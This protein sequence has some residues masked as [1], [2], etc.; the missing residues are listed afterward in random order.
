MLAVAPTLPRL[1]TWSRQTIRQHR[2]FVML[3]GAATVLRLLVLI[4]YRPAFWYDGDSGAYL[5]LAGRA[6]RP[7]PGTALGYVVFLKVLRHTGTLFSV[8]AVQ[9]LLGLAVAV[10]I[11]ALL[12]RRGVRKPLALVAVVP[13]LFDSFL[14][15]IEHYVL[16]ETVYM[17]LL[18]LAVTLLLWWPR[19]N[20]MVCLTAGL[21]LA[22]AW[23]VKPLALPFV[24]GI[25][26]YLAIRRL[27]WR[28]CGAFAAA[29]V[30]PYAG[31]LIW[32]GGHTSPY[33]ANNLAYY[34]R[35]AGFADCEHLTLT[36]TERAICPAPD[37]R[38]H[39][40]DWYAWVEASPGFA[41]RQ[42]RA[43]DPI[44]RQFAVDVV[45]QQPL[46]YLKAVGRETA[47]HFFDQVDP[48]P[49]FHCLDG[50]YTLPDTARIDGPAVPQCHPEM[51]SGNFRAPK[52]DPNENPG[53]NALTEL[54]SRYSK[55]VRTPHVA[56]TGIYLLVAAAGLVFLRRRRGA[57]APN[58]RGRVYDGRPSDGRDA[59]ALVRDAVM[60][61]T[62]CLTIIVLPV[63]VG[64][65]EPRYALPAL[66]L[67]CLALGL[68]G[69]SFTV[70]SRSAALA[71]IEA[72][73]PVS[74][75]DVT[76]RAGSVPAADIAAA[77]RTNAVADHNNAAD[78]TSGADRKNGTD[79]KNGADRK[80][81]DE[82][83]RPAARRPAK[84]GPNSSYVA[85]ASRP[86]Q[87]KPMPAA[88]GA[89]DEGHAG[90]RG[91][92]RPG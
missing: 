46:D 34:G 15:T 59:G 5:T 42:S 49:D 47:A 65:Y 43:D 4:A 54:L 81:A 75:V 78:R 26:G 64:M 44:L 48:G 3:L 90:D 7:N 83:A 70:R 66:P 21:V 72:V 19:P 27:G 80:H 11:Y 23:Y 18:V 38:G 92:G 85:R 17:S 73:A 86:G 84:R 1:R 52:K 67:L 89:S 13:L 36:P 91:G 51:A 63:L 41:Y 40:P 12:L 22:G 20:T 14:I 45:R 87:V 50:R 57:V 24:L 71:G 69:R 74:P 62:L 2:P 30:V 6:L 77:D 9:H 53:P 8:V 28:R 79:R 31:V 56:V 88:A 58:P 76:G 68:A 35:V 60:L 82:P 29:F 10:A 32:V 39:R 33:G 37:L 61:A 16:V 55:Y 25:L